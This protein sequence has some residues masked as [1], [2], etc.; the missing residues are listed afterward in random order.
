M[1]VVQDTLRKCNPGN[2]FDKCVPS[3]QKVLSSSG[4]ATRRWPMY[5]PIRRSVP[6]R[7]EPD[8]T[9][10]TDSTR[11]TPYLFEWILV[12]ITSIP[13]EVVVNFSSAVNACFT[14]KYRVVSV[15]ARWSKGEVNT[16]DVTD[17]QRI[18]CCRKQTRVFYIPMAWR[19][20]SKR[21]SALIVPIVARQA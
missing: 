1:Q 21:N 3:V 14:F 9:F 2:N 5:F 7:P 11:L 16:L 15:T 6:A 13:N 18:G 4:H 20:Q 8:N 12:P 19:P 17:T 10:W